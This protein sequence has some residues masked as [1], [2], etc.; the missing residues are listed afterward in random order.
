M[1]RRKGKKEGKEGEEGIGKMYRPVFLIEDDKND[2]R[3]EKDT[4]F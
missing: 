1:P 2:N 3:R 4:K